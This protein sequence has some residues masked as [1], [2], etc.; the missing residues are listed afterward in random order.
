M[1]KIT[2]KVDMEIFEDRLKDLLICALEGGSNYWYKIEDYIYPSGQ[3]K[4]SLEI[5][6]EHV[7]L[8][9]KNGALMIKDTL[10]V[11]DLKYRLDWWSIHRGTQIMSKNY[12]K[13][14]NDFINENDDAITADVWLQCCIFCEVIYS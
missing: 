10:D 6:L 1:K 12:L 2:V 4:D 14:F 8:P 11:T 3:N 7:E 9:F 13:H 5:E